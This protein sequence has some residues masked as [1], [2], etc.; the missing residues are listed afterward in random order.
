MPLAIE[1]VPEAQFAAWVA[2]KGGKMPGPKG[3]A[4]TQTG[5]TDTDNVTLPPATPGTATA[6]PAPAPRNPDVANR[7]NQ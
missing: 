6:N 3:P 1:V 4:P 7:E 5:G 2:S